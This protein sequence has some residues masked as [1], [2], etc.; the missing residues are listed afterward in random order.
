[1]SKREARH[2]DNSHSFWS[3]PSRS[4][5]YRDCIPA[6]ATMHKKERAIAPPFKRLLSLPVI[7]CD[8]IDTDALGTFTGEIARRG[9]MRDVAGQKARLACRISG[10]RLGIGSEG[11]FGPHPYIPFAAVDHELIAFHDRELGTTICESVLSLRTN[12]LHLDLNE[13]SDLDDFLERIGFPEHAVVVGRADGSAPWIKGVQTRRDLDIA[14]RRS[15]EQDGGSTIRVSTDMRAHVNPTRMCII[16]AAATRLAQRIKVLCPICAAPGFGIVDWK[17][18]VPCSECGAPT[19]RIAAKVL[20]C[21]RC[22]YRQ[23]EPV[24]RAP[25]ADPKYCS[26]CNP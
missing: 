24:R 12:F 22:S 23:V 17:R 18:D 11:S 21:A 15:A 13:S 14:I 9:S 4:H 10:R 3:A 7:T 1:M 5:P 20:G 19:E 26:A 25:L 8:A 16:R 2:D 6:L